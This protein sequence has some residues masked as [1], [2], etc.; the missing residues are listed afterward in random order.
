MA[1]RINYNYEAAVTY[2]SLKQNERLLNKSLLRLSTGLRILSA[3]DDASGLFIA[4]QL[5]V[6]SAGLEQGNRNIQFAISALQIAEGGVAQIFDKLKKMYQKAVSAAND[7]N[8]PN[9]RQSLQR[10]I[11]KLADA[12]Q[13]IGTDTEYN[14][15]KLLDGTFI[16]K[17]IHYGARAGQTLSVS[18][19]DVRATSIGGYLIQAPG[20]ATANPASNYAGL[21]TGNWQFDA[22]TDTIQVAGVDLTNYIWTNIYNST[23]GA[24]DAKAIADAINSNAQL[25]EQGISATASNKSVAEALWTNISPTAGAVTINIYVGPDTATPVATVTVNT[26]ETLTLQD[27]ISQVNSQASA[28]GSSLRAYEQDG[29]LVLET[30]GETIGVEVTTA[31]GDSVDLAQFLQVPVGN[32]VNGATGSAVKVGELNIAG[33]N[34]YSYD[35]TGIT[36]ATEGLGIAATGLADFQNLYSIDVT[37]NEGAERALLILSKAIQKVDIE[38]SKIGSAIIN[39]QSIYDAQAVAKDNTDNAENVIRNVDFAKEMTEFTKYQIRMQSGVA[40]LAQANTLPQ[41][42]LQLLR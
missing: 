15:I 21:I 23:A 20:K 35:F 42:V 22:A 11:M 25:Q 7:I 2:T 37:T 29:R 24:V 33:V 32:N 34:S 41:L 39:L 36:S 40:M 26:G 18:I 14:G 17:Q 3:A 19:V 1:T 8:D 30:N 12:I 6:V 16:D 28:N 31:A 4:D 27:F 10:D 9:A 13:K 38:R 5:A